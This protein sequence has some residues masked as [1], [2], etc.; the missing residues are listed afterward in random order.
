M[1]VFVWVLRL[2]LTGMFFVSALLAVWMWALYARTPQ[3]ELQVAH[4]TE[5]LGAAYKLYGDEKVGLWLVRTLIHNKGPGAIRDVRVRYT[6]TDYTAPTDHTIDIV[7]EGQRIVD[8]YYPIVNESITKETSGRSLP[9]KIE[10]TYRHPNGRTVTKA[11]DRPIRVMGRNY[12]TWTSMPDDEIIN[13][14]DQFANWPLVGVFMTPNEEVTKT[15][16]A[17]CTSGLNTSSDDEDRIRAWA[18][19]FYCLRNYGVRYIQEPSDAWTPHF[20]QYVQFPKDSI[21]RKAGTC[22]D[23]ALLFASMA[24]AVGIDAGIALMPGHAIPWIR[25]QNGQYVFVEST[26]VDR[27]YAYSHFPEIVSPRVS[28]EESVR[29]AEAFVKKNLEQGTLILADYNELRK[30]GVVSPW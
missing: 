27:N 16:G 20:N 13:W 12:L 17:A 7:L 11:L 19:I 8:F 22:L 14:Y 25:L 3:V 9:V 1:R 23:L 2:G 6:M 18:A 21:Q 30:N 4:K 24:Q 29:V 15:A 28:F 26:F 10:V 5:L